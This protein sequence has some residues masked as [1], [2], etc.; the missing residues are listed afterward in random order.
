ME[1]DEETSPSKKQRTKV[2][3]D[4]DTELSNDEASFLKGPEKYKPRFILSFDS[5]SSS[6]PSDFSQVVTSGKYDAREEIE[7]RNKSARERLRTELYQFVDKN[8][9]KLSSV[10]DMDKE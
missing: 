10:L 5:T 6:A 2:L 8:H 4:L 3:E 1:V 7:T 9:T